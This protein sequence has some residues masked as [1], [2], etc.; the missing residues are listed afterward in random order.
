MN[1][2]REDFKKIMSIL[3]EEISL[4]DKLYDLGI[5]IINCESSYSASKIV[6]ILMPLVEN[7][8]ITDC[9]NAYLF[10]DCIMFRDN[11]DNKYIIR[12]DDEFY[13]FL[14]KL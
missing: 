6:D 14:C 10:E 12:S 8:T 3:K 5:D 2:K 13:N 4:S 7:D 9:I 11:D 1:L